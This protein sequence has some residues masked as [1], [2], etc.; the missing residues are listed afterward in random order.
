MFTGCYNIKGAA[1]ATDIHTQFPVASTYAKFGDGNGYLTAKNVV[2]GTAYYSMDYTGIL[3]LS[4][5]TGTIGYL[6]NMGTTDNG[7][8]ADWHRG[9]HTI[10][11]NVKQF[12]VT[13][14]AF[15]YTW[16]GDM[17]KPIVSNDTTVSGAQNGTV[18]SMIRDMAKL[19]DVDLS[20]FSLSGVTNTYAMI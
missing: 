14:K 8:N 17:A 13:D 10:R 7:G 1:G 3:T 11:A 19:I 4:P 12:M 9:H 16:D 5:L 18:M 2:W 6:P 20:H 15:G